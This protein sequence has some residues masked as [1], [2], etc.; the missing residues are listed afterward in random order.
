MS[1][2]R[3]PTV[4]SSSRVA[5]TV[6]PAGL[7]I[8]L[9]LSACAAPK[10]D[11]NIDKRAYVRG[12]RAGALE[13]LYRLAP[14]A[15]AEVEMAPGYAV[16]DTIQSQILISSTGNGYGIAR[17]NGT[18]RDTYMSALG[19]GAGLGVGVKS[20]K[21]VVIFR[22]R[23]VL[24]QFVEEGWVF[25]ASGTAAA[26]VGESGAATSGAA[27]FDDRLKIYTFTE[28]GI[29]AGVSLRGA[30]VWKDDRLNY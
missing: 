26:K 18:G 20:H 8:C 25:G 16:F 17:D 29:M 10:G 13:T 6:V 22:D 3:L 9:L 23:E 19:F 2:R 15:V 14:Q 12:M 27:A 28:T 30:K 4:Q 21:V 7:L 5:R 11:T 24:R 1:G